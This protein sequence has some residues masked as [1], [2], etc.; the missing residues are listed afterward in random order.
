MV[1][2]VAA[3]TGFVAA[4]PRF[5]VELGGAVAAVARFVAAL[6]GPVAA[7]GRFVTIESVQ[8]GAVC[9]Y[10]DKSFKNKVVKSSVRELRLN[11]VCT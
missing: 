1:S 3:V 10:F 4:V 9:T 6:G 8:R 5:L 7:V 11:G 2:F